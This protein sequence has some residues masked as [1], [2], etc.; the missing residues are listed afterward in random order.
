MTCGYEVVVVTAFGIESTE[1]DQPVA[2]DIGIGS[3]S[4]PYLSI[5]YFVTWFQYS[6]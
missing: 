2:H 5:V 6:L 4:R 1:L 3:E